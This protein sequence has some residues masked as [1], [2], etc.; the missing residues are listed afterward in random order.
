MWHMRWDG[1]RLRESEASAHE[2]SGS[3][4]KLRISYALHSFHNYGRA[5]TLF[6][7]IFERIYEI[8]SLFVLLII[9]YIRRWR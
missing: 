6:L 8:I 1:L 9:L 2:W 7:L 4:H 5:F 3:A